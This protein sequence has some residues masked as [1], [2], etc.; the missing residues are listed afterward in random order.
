[1][2]QTALIYLVYFLLWSLFAFGSTWAGEDFLSLPLFFWGTCLVLPFLLSLFLGLVAFK[3]QKVQEVLPQRGEDSL[4]GEAHSFFLG[5]RKTTA[6][7]LAMTL[8]ATYVSGSTFLAGPSIALRTGFSWVLL[9]SIQ[10]P[11]LF[12][13]IQI[14]G[15]RFIR[16]RK[17]FSFLTILD[18]LKARYPSKSLFYLFTFFFSL[19]LLLVMVIQLMAAGRIME[20]ILGMDYTMSL[21][22]FLLFVVVYTLLGG[23]KHVVLTDVI[24]MGLIIL[25]LLVFAV[26]IFLRLGDEPLSVSLSSQ[27]PAFFDALGGGMF[28]QSY[29]FSLWVLL[30]W[31]LLGSPPIVSRL[32]SLRSSVSLPKMA[33]WATLVLWVL[34]IGIHTL[35]VLGAGFAQGLPAN[36]TAWISLMGRLLG[37]GGEVIFTLVPLMA[38]MSTVDTLLLIF[39]SLIWSLYHGADRGEKQSALSFSKGRFL[40]TAGSALLV[41]VFALYPPDFLVWLNLFALALSQ[42]IFF[43]PLFLG[44]W[45]FRGNRAG[46][47]ASVGMGLLSFALWQGIF[48]GST[49]MPHSILISLLVSVLSYWLASRLINSTREEREA[50]AIF[51]ETLEGN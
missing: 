21:F 2:T 41:F 39:V 34:V 25:F 32:L 26:A 43:A 17:R 15:E 27:P 14:M 33:F 47:W 44:L 18:L 3:S 45:D 13:V 16:L 35:P 46:V 51:K 28:S 19:S 50:Q 22:C 24:Q 10:L 7:S 9:A 12:L 36:D 23:F 30:G 6:F 42:V 20:A 38:S 5:D 8:V 31:G 1:V 4:K 37:R 48:K 29:F 11:G 40:I 49:L